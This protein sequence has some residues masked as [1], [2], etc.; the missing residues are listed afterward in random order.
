M[1][2]DEKVYCMDC[3]FLNNDYE[4]DHDSNYEVNENGNWYKPNTK[5][6]VNSPHFMNNRNDC[7][8][9]KKS[10]EKNARVRPKKN[11]PE[12]EN[13]H[14]KALFVRRVNFRG[15]ETL[16]EEWCCPECK[17]FIWVER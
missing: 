1:S 12:C 2:D 5:N 3:A 17:M 11:I 16:G 7:K 4:C 13:C 8:N 10:E 14:V 9:F 6:Y 15:V